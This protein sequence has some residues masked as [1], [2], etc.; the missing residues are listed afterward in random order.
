MLGEVAGGARGWLRL[1]AALDGGVRVGVVE[2]ALSLHSQGAREAAARQ[3]VRNHAAVLSDITNPSTKLNIRGDKP[4]TQ[5]E[6]QRVAYEDAVFVDQFLRECARRLLGGS[7]EM[8]ERLDPSTPAQAQAWCQAA[9]YLEGRIQSTADQMPGRERDMSP[10]AAAAMVA[11]M[12]DVSRGIR[13]WLELR[14]LLA[15]NTHAVATDGVVAAH[16]YAAR[17]AA[18]RKLIMN[19]SDVLRD[20][21]NPSPT[22]NIDGKPLTQPELQ[23]VPVED[24]AYAASFLREVRRRLVGHRHAHTQAHAYTDVYVHACIHAGDEKAH[25]TM[26]QLARVGGAA[27]SIADTAGGGMGTIG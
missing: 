4:L 2:G 27:R 21:T 20:M 23:R 10:A 1:R 8:E 5:T 25:R 15:G 6:L 17:H 18:A 3:L 26:P 16:S 13:A 7:H 9:A 12:R 24:A 14:K 19:H 22:H 11:T